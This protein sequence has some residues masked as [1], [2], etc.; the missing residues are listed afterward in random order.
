MVGAGHLGAAGIGPVGA[1]LSITPLA[2]VASLAELVG[3]DQDR[4]T[5]KKP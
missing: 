3:S 5:G 2:A 1:L 4:I